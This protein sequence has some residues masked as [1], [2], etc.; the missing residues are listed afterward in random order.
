MR[1]LQNLLGRLRLFADH[2]RSQENAYATPAPDYDRAMDSKQRTY[3]RKAQVIADALNAATLNANALD[4]DRAKEWAILE[5]GCGAGHFTLALAEQLPFAKIVATEYFPAMAKLASAKLAAHRNVRVVEA[6]AYASLDEKFD[7]VCC[8]D[9][10]HHL[11]DPAAALAKWRDHAKPGARLLALEANPA[12]PALF[13]AAILHPEERRFYL[14]NPR[15][16]KRWAAEA[17]WKD[18]SVENLPFYLPA[19]PE[20]WAGCLDRAEDAIHR[21]RGVWGRLS[22]LFL[23]QASH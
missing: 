10:L 1:A 6:S 19:G 11:D 12:N 21:G 7:V 14:N 2:E 15:N 22:G 4:N 17:G 5:A 9:V 13:A 18:A 3:R 20:A 16:L 8:V 23:L